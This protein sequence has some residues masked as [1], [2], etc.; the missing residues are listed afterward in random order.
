M[1]EKDVD[2]LPELLDDLRVLAADGPVE[3]PGHIEERLRM[4]FRRQK[5]R[6]NLVRWTPWLGVAAAAGIA[7]LVWVRSESPK[8][9]PAPAVAA[10]HAVAPVAPPA[11]EE[12]TD[13]FYPLPEAEAL[14]AVENAMVVRVQL[15]VSSLQLMGVPVNAES[16]DLNVQADL[17]LGQDGLARA[18]RLV[19]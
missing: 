11:T 8:P 3:A 17:L 19:E 16:A 1:N 18:V 13:G 10:V 2:N 5:R 6:R 4:E 14:P 12:E 7:L 15:P 9:A